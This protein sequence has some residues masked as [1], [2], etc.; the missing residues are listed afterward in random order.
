MRSTKKVKAV[1]L[2]AIV[3]L[4]FAVAMS[5]PSG[6]SAQAEE[7]PAIRLGQGR[8]GKMAWA[9]SAEAPDHP[10][11]TCVS[12]AT[13]EPGIPRGVEGSEVTNCA[14]PEVVPLTEVWASRYGVVF[15]GLFRPDARRLVLVVRG[16]PPIVQLLG[17]KQ[18]HAQEGMPGVEFSFAARAF[19]PHTCIR[20]VRAFDGKG[21]VVS[22]F[23]S[24]HC[25]G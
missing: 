13:V 19:R 2:A 12:I 8:V 23:S 1:R 4:V 21:R 3:W 20:R 15:A 14:K 10:T 5:L 18:F 22:S 6:A 16:R 11:E 17:H 9:A 24:G 7:V 25:I